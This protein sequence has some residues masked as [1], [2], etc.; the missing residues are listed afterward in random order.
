MRKI[1]LFV[2]GLIVFLLIS[3]VAHVVDIDKLVAGLDSL[4]G[5]EAPA[6]TRQTKYWSPINKTDVNTELELK[7]PDGCSYAILINNATNIV[8]SWRFTSD[9]SQCNRSSYAPSL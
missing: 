4:V 1:L 6:Y 8:E 3:C 5:K 7:R 2:S 9:Q